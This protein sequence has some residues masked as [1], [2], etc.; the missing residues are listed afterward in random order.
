MARP[1]IKVVGSW[2]TPQTKLPSSKIS[3]AIRYHSLRGKYLKSF[4]HVDW[5]PVD[6]QRSSSETARRRRESEFLLCTGQIS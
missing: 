5:K 4:P 3:M 1:T 6:C 2:A